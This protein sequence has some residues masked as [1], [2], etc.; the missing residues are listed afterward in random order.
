MLQAAADRLVA[1]DGPMFLHVITLTNHH[2]YDYIAQHRG[3]VPGTIEEEFLRS[4]AY[5]DSAIEGFM[6]RLEV[7]GILDDCLI[8]IYSDHDSAIDVKMEAHLDTFYPRL[9]A[10][11][12]PLVMIGFDRAPQRV[13]AIVGLQDVPVMVLEELGIAPPLTFLGNGWD[14]WG[15]TYSASHAGWQMAGDVVVPWGWPVDAETLTRLAINHP[16]ELLEP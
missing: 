12:V 8:V 16:E 11:T 4:V 10:D 15:R 13:D 14:K 9:I 1:S 5:V 7:E 2:P 3:E 6:Q